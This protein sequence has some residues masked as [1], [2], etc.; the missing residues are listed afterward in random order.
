MTASLLAS[1]PDFDSALTALLNS[2]NTGAADVAHTVKMIIGDV[3]DRGDKA[4]LDYTKKFDRVE[5]ASIRMSAAQISVRS[6]SGTA[7]SSLPCPP[8]ISARLVTGNIANAEMAPN[9][10]TRSIAGVIW[11]PAGVLSCP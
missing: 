4:L 9:S 5:L 11:S 1:Q 2:R 8:R 7:A 3:R 6:A 10:N